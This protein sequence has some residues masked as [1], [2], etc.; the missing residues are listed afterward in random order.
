MIVSGLLKQPVAL[1][2]SNKRLV[3][4]VVIGKVAAIVSSAAVEEEGSEGDYDD[5]G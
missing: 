2:G 1:F 4:L 5:G 3:V